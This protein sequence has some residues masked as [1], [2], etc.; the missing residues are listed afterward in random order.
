MDAFERF[1]QAV[2]MGPLALIR[3]R[4]EVLLAR[5]DA[6]TDPLIREHREELERIASVPK[7]VDREFLAQFDRDD[8]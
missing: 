5:G 3:L 7:L 6:F 2:K 4:A 8:D 1:S